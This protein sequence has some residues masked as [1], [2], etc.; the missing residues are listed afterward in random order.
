MTTTDAPAKEIA[1]LKRRIGR[2]ELW[3]WIERA[4]LV[5]LIYTQRDAIGAGMLAVGGVALGFF[6]LFSIIERMR[7]S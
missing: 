4:V 2:I 5:I 6:V 1:E 3:G 7:K